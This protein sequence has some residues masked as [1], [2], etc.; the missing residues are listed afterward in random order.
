MSEVKC[1]VFISC[2][3]VV[4]L[5]TILIS[6]CVLPSS[7]IHLHLTLLPQ[8]GYRKPSWFFESLSL[9]NA[10]STLHHEDTG[11]HRVKTVI[12]YTRLLRSIS[13]PAHLSKL[14]SVYRYSRITSCVKFFA[15]LKDS[16]FIH[17][18]RHLR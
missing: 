12:V 8:T 10:L 11:L 1:N 7:K 9:F 2:V 3:H 13:I 17:Y 4:L 14:I 15:E 16:I 5:S 6:K 18:V